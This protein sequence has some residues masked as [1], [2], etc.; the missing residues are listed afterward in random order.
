MPKI[1]EQVEKILDNALV[2]SFTCID[3]KNR[4][5]THPLLPLYDKTQGKLYFT[6]SILFSKKLEHIKNNPKVSVLFSNRRHIPN[7]SDEEFHVVLIK[8]DAVVD[9]TD[10]H[11]GWEKLIPLW[12]RKEPYIMAFIKQRIALPLFW[13][14]AVIEVEPRKIYVW[15]HGDMNRDPILYEVV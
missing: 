15:E 7:I 1:P 9:E 2:C 13:E 5:I 12:Q 14:R 6:S 11:H 3:G 10:I 4:P 8:G